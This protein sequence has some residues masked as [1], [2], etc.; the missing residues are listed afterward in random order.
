MLISSPTARDT[1]RLAIWKNPLPA[2]AGVQRFFSVN[3]A[4][5]PYHLVL[6]CLA[7]GAGP[8]LGVRPH[9]LNHDP[10]LLEY[11]EL[12]TLSVCHW[13]TLVGGEEAG[14]AAT[15]HSQDRRVVVRGELRGRSSCGPS[16]PARKE[17][18]L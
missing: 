2:A 13:S 8:V 3:R 1:P 6:V 10:N 9:L 16:S 11:R 14:R 17:G 15:S 12:K 18:T 4:W 7:A 5:S